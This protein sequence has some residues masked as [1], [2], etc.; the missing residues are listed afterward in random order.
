[1]ANGQLSGRRAL[2]TGGSRGIGRAIAARLTDAGAEVA[3]IARDP[4]GVEKALADGVARSGFAADVCDET[5]FR[6][7]IARLAG[8][9]PFD[10]AI[11][12]AGGAET[13]RFERTDAAFFHRMFDLNLIATVTTFHATLPTM[14]TAGFGRL[15]AV[16][17][18]AAHRGYRNTSAYAAAKH[19]VLGLVRSLALEV[20]GSGVT[21]NAVSPGFTD[22]DLI[23]RAATAMAARGNIS[24]EAAKAG[25]AVDN[26]RGR[27]IEP[28]EVAEAV[29][30]LC[31]EGAGA[32]N[33][34][35]L[36]INGGEF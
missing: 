20:A 11:A 5:A 34:Q 15:I 21:A 29:L 23:G 35:S 12:N 19:A 4:A 26:P 2:V 6:A 27:L 1:M 9:R 24:A 3:I 33:G 22:T 28:H 10:I 17:S 32:V 36:L 14:R 31:G 8:D 13:A 16:A 30:Y 7:A 25:F 18:T